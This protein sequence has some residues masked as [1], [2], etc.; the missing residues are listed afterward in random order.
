MSNI[1]YFGIGLIALG[2]LIAPGNDGTA[3]AQDMMRHVDLQSPAFT[4]SELTRAEL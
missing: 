1:S 4:Q 2:V 3:R